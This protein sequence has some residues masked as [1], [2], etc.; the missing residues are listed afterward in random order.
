MLHAV[1]LS[2][3]G[4]FDDAADGGKAYDVGKLPCQ[5]PVWLSLKVLGD[6]FHKRGAVIYALNADRGPMLVENGSED[7]VMD[8]P[9][10]GP[11]WFDSIRRQAIALHGS[12]HWMFTTHV[13]PGK[14]HRTAWVER[15]GVTW[16]NEQLHFALWTPAQI[17]AMPTTHVSEWIKANHVD[18][19]EYYLAENRE[20]GLDALGRGLPGIPR[21]DLMVLPE[22]DW[23]RLQDQLLYEAWSAK[24]AKAEQSAGSTDT[25]AA[26]G[27][28]PL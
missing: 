5:A 25:V 15:P 17:A 16:L 21:S 14:R 23:Q 12:D 19:S 2:G 9:H 20:G 3:G 10:R 4:T 26:P 28:K 1:L 24:T 6:E 11:E 22:A 8:I 7:D 18:I 13:D 27:S